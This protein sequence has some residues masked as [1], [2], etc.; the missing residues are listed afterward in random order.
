MQRKRK[1]GES[2]MA[3]AYV[4]KGSE[5]GNLG[6]YGNHKRALQAAIAYVNQTQDPT[7]EVEIRKV[8]K[9]YTSVYGSYTSAEVE[10]FPIE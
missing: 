10:T 4:V 1:H 7:E 9:F 3:Y 6:V 8:H 5:D 2:K